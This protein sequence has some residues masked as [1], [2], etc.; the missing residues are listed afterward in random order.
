MLFLE[1]LFFFVSMTFFQRRYWIEDSAAAWR[2][3]HDLL[4][5]Y[6]VTAR[7][8]SCG[9]VMFLV[10]SDC[11]H[12]T[13]ILVV[14]QPW[15][16]R[17]KKPKTLPY[18]NPLNISKI[19]HMDFIRQGPTTPSTHKRRFTSHWKPSCWQYQHLSPLQ[20]L[21]VCYLH[22]WHRLFVYWQLGHIM[23]L[24]ASIILVSIWKSV[25]WLAEEVI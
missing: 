3:K 10:V 21:W 4:K 11:P 5:Y 14:T 15:L 13:V 12:V 8:L 20:T 24:F 19:V 6:S 9:K 17:H 18:R 2:M 1:I 22:F 25:T 16:P 23:Y 7:Q